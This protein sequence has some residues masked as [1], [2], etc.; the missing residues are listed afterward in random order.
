MHGFAI[1]KGVMDT[2][3]TDGLG[4]FSIDAPGSIRLDDW[5]DHDGVGGPRVAVM[6]SRGLVLGAGREGDRSWALVD[7]FANGAPTCVRDARS[8]PIE[9]AD[10]AKFGQSHFEL[11][12]ADDEAGYFYGPLGLAMPQSTSLVIHRW[13]HP[14]TYF[15]AGSSVSG[16]HIARDETYLYFS[17]GSAVVRVPK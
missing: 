4:Y 10:A 2:S 6:T 5:L 14:G 17:T 13:D 15:A 12:D 9:F 1:V 11:V 16:R 8:T 7:V 3:P